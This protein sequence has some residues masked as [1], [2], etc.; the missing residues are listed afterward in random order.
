MTSLK[1]NQ[2]VTCSNIEDARI[3]ADKIKNGVI[4]EKNN[5]FL[6]VNYKTY[7]DL[8]SQGYTQVR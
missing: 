3:K 8:K 4:V 6:I 2:S 5:T 1:T 7:A